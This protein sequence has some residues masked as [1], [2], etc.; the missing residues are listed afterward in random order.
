MER[1]TQESLGYVA[2]IFPQIIETAYGQGDLER[3]MKKAPADQ[4]VRDMGSWTSASS[5]KGSKQ[6]QWARF[7]YP[8]VVLNLDIKKA[9]PLEGAEMAFVKSKS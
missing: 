3:E 9:L 8:T 6:S 5:R 4:G 2:D 7:W 1:F